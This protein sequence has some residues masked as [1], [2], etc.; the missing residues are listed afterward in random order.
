[1]HRFE[2][3]PTSSRGLRAVP[4]K[5]RVTPTRVHVHLAERSGPRS[6]VPEVEPATHP[7]QRIF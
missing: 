6:W 5:G 7:E 3:F 1:M 4:R 2:S